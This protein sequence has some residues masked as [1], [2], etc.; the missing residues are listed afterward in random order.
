MRFSTQLII[1]AACAVIGIAVL[2]VPLLVTQIYQ[3]QTNATAH[4]HNVTASAARA[5]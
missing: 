2:V 4:V 3:P 1:D 5:N